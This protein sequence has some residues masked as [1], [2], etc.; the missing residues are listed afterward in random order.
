M[1]IKRLSGVHAPH[2]KNTAE[3]A[4]QR[5]PTPDKVIIPMNMHIGAPATPVVKAG[6]LV[7][8]GQVIG[9]AAGFVSVPIHASVSG[10]VV[11]IDEVL[12]ANG[13]K[14]KAVVIEADGLQEVAETVVPPTV[15]TA[16][17]FLAAVRASGLVGL[18][19]AGFPTVVKLSVK[20]PNSID[21]LLINGAECEPYIT[22]DL[23][24][25][26]DDCAHILKGAA[27]IKKFIGQKKTILGIEDNKPE[28]IKLFQ[29]KTANNADFEVMAMPSLYPQGGEKVLIHNAT[30]RDVPEGKLPL[31]VG[32]IVINVTT[33]AFISKYIETG[34]PLIEKCLTVDG[35]AVAKPGNVFAPIGTPI[36]KIFEFCGGYKA[37]PRKI[38]YG[39]PMMG[40][41]VP[42]DEVPLLKNNNA[43]LA[44]AEKEATLAP[45][46]ACIKCGRCVGACP[47]GLMPATIEHAFKIK[48]VDM[49]NELK[50]MLC[51]ECGCCSFVCPAKRELVL[52]NKLAKSMVREA[53]QKK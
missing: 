6:D 30:G 34:M 14:A 47:V 49:L 20:N 25:M 24:T 42:S 35:S 39:G 22:S 16:E 29:E 17:Q 18:G 38:L 1:S 12:M 33:L 43:V 45:T 28:A 37:E 26:L 15:E 40:I 10:K 2:H 27:L 51:M 44:F 7:K 50:V 23:R 19:G 53:S 36:A 11:K 32:C 48:N 5:I 41:S 9:E 4:P 8:V 21:Y 46:T 31:D 13:A 3:C 52:T